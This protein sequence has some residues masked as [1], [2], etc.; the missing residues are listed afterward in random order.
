MFKKRQPIYTDTLSRRYWLKR[1]GIIGLLVGLIGIFFWRFQNNQ[2]YPINGVLLGQ[3]DGYLDFDQL[4]NQKYEFV[5]LE[6]T[7]GAS[8]FDDRF[9]SN[10]Q[11]ANGSLLKV[12]VSHYFS[13]DSDAQNQFYYFKQQVGSQVGDL[14]IMITVDLYGDYQKDYP[15]KQQLVPALQAL[16][17][18]LEETYQKTCIINTT[19]EIL[20]RYQLTDYFANFCLNA[21]KKTQTKQILFWQPTKQQRWSL[22]QQSKYRQLYFVAAKAKW[23]W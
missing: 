19:P 1:L 4:E 22:N 21:D 15:S 9:E 18:H 14:P 12:G 20:A 3:T 17:K 23:Q 2:K 10:Y 6:A 8:Y 16:V 5:Y 11:R 7:K 13:F